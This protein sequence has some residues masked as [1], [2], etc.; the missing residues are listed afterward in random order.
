MAKAM[1]DWT[2]NI[3]AR[4]WR[5]NNLNKPFQIKME[6]RTIETCCFCG[7]RTKAGIYMRHDPKDL[8]C[9]H[10]EMNDNG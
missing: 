4:C 2:H 5:R 8:T 1:N 6:H 7:Q 3:C 9:N 10:K